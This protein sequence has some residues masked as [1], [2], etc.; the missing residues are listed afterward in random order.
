MCVPI[1]IV[2]GHADAL[3]PDH[4]IHAAAADD[5]G[6]GDGKFVTLGSKLFAEMM[7]EITERTKLKKTSLRIAN[8]FLFNN[9]YMNEMNEQKKKN[10]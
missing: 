7:R 8:D 2:Q 5:D 4:N 9:N 3:F 6:Y 1:W 10:K